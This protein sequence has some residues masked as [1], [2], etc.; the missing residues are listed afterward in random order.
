M[1]PPGGEARRRERRA[2]RQVRRLGLRVGRRRRV[3]HRA[4]RSH[5]SL[6]QAVSTHFVDTVGNT[7]HL[8]LGYSLRS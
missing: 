1:A 7:V 6:M 8:W 3:Q 4:V 5:A 2:A